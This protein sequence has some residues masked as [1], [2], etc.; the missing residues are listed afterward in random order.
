[1]KK[2]S[3]A[4]VELESCLDD[5]RKLLKKQ[6]MMDMQSHV[7]NIAVALFNN[8]HSTQNK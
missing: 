4:V 1:M 2:E 6:N 8:R 7:I 5:A 3:S